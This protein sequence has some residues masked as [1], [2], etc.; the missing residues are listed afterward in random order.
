MNVSEIEISYKSKAQENV[1][2]RNSNDVYD[3][4][5]SKWNKDIIEYQEEVKLLLLNKSN[6]VLGTVDLAK[7]GTTGCIVDIKIIVAIAL[8]TN[9]HGIILIHN[10]PSGNLNPSIRDRDITEKLQK[11]CNYL[12]LKLLD[13]LIISNNG[14]FSFADKELLQ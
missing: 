5:L 6:K 4:I 12:D 13:H 10:H 14:Y 1:V 2:I 7:G 11:A 9:S 3:L 8:K